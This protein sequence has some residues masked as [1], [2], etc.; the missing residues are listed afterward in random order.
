VNSELSSKVAPF[1]IECNSPLL[2]GVE[3]FPVLITRLFIA[4]P[5]NA[6]FVNKQPRTGA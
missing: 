4:A 3:V 5:N 1:D 6:I 2:A